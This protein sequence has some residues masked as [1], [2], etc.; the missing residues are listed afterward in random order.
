MHAVLG[1]RR[2]QIRFTSRVLWYAEN[3]NM[4]FEIVTWHGAR[5]HIAEQ[6][7]C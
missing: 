6:Q 3:R 2:V 1:R 5:L 7:S 4:P